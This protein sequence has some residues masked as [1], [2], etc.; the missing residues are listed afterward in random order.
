MTAEE[1]QLTN[2]YQVLRAENKQDP[3]GITA[4]VIDVA[5]YIIAKGTIDGELI[6]I[7]ELHIALFVL[8]RECLTYAREP[9]HNGTFI[10]HKR[11][12]IVETVHIHFD[13]GIR[14]KHLYPEIGVIKG[15][16][17]IDIALTR[18]RSLKPKELEHEASKLNGAWYHTWHKQGENSEIPLYL[19]R[20]KG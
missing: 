4:D 17:L 9:F 3:A 19:I 13:H 2:L 7:W 10:A 16:A 20:A 1:K 8:Q 18:L 12:P 5:K 15:K 14:L 11:G 6:N